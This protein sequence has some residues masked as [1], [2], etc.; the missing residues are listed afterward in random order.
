[1]NEIAL[2]R[3]KGVDP[4]HDKPMRMEAHGLMH[5]KK[6]VGGRAMRWK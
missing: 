4:D 6:K 1:M 5:R 3:D 2:L